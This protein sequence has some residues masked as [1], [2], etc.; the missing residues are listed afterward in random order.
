M[1][2]QRYVS[3]VA[4]A[5]ASAISR[6][7]QSQVAVSDATGIPRTTLI[8][9]LAGSS[10]FTTAELS[11]IGELLQVDPRDFLPELERVSA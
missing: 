8:R 4:R 1:D 3:E 11:A 10:P 2:T 9:R 5:V 6:A 7:D